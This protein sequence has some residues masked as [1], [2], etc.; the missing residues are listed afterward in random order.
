MKK[1]LISYKLKSGSQLKKQAR[2]HY[3]L[4]G[5]KAQ[6][7]LTILHGKNQITYQGLKFQAWRQPSLKDS[8]LAIKLIKQ[9]QRP[10]RIWVSQRMC[11]RKHSL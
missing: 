2:Q 10:C 11:Q 5:K 7:S 9:M 6:M 1:L 4:L 3:L 8:R